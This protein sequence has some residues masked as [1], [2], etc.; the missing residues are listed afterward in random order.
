MSEWKEEDNSCT[1]VITDFWIK[2]NNSLK[3]QVRPPEYKTVQKV[4]EQQLVYLRKGKYLAKITQPE[5]L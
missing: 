2:G 5:A 1:S 4:S 3:H